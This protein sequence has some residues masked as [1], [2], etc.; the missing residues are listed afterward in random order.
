M[1]EVGEAACAFV[2]SGARPPPPPCALAPFFVFARPPARWCCVGFGTVL[3]HVA[4]R[5]L[6][7]GAWRLLRRASRCAPGRAWGPSGRGAW[8]LRPRSVGERRR[9]A[10]PGMGYRH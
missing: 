3:G 8:P 6:V 2:V 5:S 9:T 1:K 4:A 10:E 7:R